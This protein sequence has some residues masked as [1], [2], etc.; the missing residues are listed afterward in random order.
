MGDI[1]RCPVVVTESTVLLEKILV[2]TIVPT[3]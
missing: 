3:I 1:P 2:H